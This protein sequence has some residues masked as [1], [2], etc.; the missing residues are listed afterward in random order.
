MHVTGFQNYAQS[1]N[2]HLF[3]NDACS[4]KTALRDP[5]KYNRCRNKPVPF[6]TLSWP[7]SVCVCVCDCATHS[8][9]SKAP[10]HTVVNLEAG[11]ALQA[12]A[13]PGEDAFCSGCWGRLQRPTQ[14]K[15]SHNEIVSPC[16]KWTQDHSTIA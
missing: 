9:V 10:I 13:G 8:P 2:Q 15:H 11:V 6:I 12:G 1:I 7:H 5:T 3:D 16:I 14:L 4:F